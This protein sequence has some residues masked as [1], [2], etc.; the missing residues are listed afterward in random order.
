MTTSQA[1]DDARWRLIEEALASELSDI[2]KLMA[3][4]CIVNSRKPLTEAE[5]ARTN[6]LAEQ[7]GWK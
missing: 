4:G 7:F 2:G 1:Q 5:I 3:I 6:Q